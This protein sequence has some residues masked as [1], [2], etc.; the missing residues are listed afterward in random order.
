[1][2][3]IFAQRTKLL[4]YPQYSGTQLYLCETPHT[5]N[6]FSYS[7]AAAEQHLNTTLNELLAVQLKNKE[8]FFCGRRSS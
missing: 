8:N 6:L 1:M 5:K 2:L 3:S 7:K 4:K